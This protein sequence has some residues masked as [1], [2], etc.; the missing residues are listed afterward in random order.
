MQ[1]SASLASHRL[2]R[3]S[4]VCARKVFL[5][6]NRCLAFMMMVECCIQ[7]FFKSLLKTLDLRDASIFT[8]TADHQF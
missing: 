7:L 8:F 3:G 4:K 5:Y 6:W 2:G 1:M